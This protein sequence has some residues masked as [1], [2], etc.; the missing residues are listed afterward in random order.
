MHA[1]FPWRT[2]ADKPK[3]S[4]MVE[5]RK[6]EPFAGLQGGWVGR[7][8]HFSL[9]HK[10]SLMFQMDFT[11]WLHGDSEDQS[12]QKWGKNRSPSSWSGSPHSHP[13]LEIFLGFGFSAQSICLYP[14]CFWLSHEPWALC[15]HCCGQ[16][17]C[18][19]SCWGR[20]SSSRYGSHSWAWVMWDITDGCLPGLKYPIQ[21]LFVDKPY[22]TNALLMVKEQLERFSPKSGR[23]EQRT[24][25]RKLWVK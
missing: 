24:Q 3:G 16:Q 10:L 22:L 21:S 13:G 15:P 12:H 11:V 8:I 18:R 14:S 2:W 4:E 9:M 23:S 1:W 19:S 17:M 5:Q 20:W 7:I 6:Q 25:W